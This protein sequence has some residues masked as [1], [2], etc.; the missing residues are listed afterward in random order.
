MKII[1]YS[2]PSGQIGYASQHPDGAA[3]ELQ[4]DPLTGM[5]KTG[6]VATVHKLLAPI[7][8]TNFLCIGLNYRRHAEE[9]NVA[10]PQFPVLFMKSTGAPPEP[11]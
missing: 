10:P 11:R 9:G 7:V 8:P 2:N 6:R 3:I 4:G 1:R 5:T